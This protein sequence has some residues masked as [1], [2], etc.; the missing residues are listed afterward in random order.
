[1]ILLFCNNLLAPA[2]PDADFTDEYQAAVAAGFAPLLISL[3]ALADG[4]ATA[5]VRRVP[6][7]SQRQTAIY[8]GWMLRPADYK[9]LYAGLAAK[10]LHLLNSLVEYLTGH[11]FPKTYAQLRDYTPLSI[12]FDLP[13]LLDMDDLMARLAVFG[14]HP[15]IVKDYVKSEKHHWHEACFIP[16]SDNRT[17]VERVTRRFLELRGAYLN[18]GLVF[19]DFVD[20]E[21]L[22]NH[23]VSGMPLSKEFRLFYFRHRLLAQSTYWSEGDYAGV[24]P[25][26]AFFDPIAAR[27]SS[28][29]FTLD[30][31]KT[32]Q[33]QWLVLE[34]GDGQVSGLPETLNVGR[35]YAQLRSI[36]D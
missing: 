29:F 14:G 6:I 8:R 3:D 28:N 34:V 22:T 21:P 25:D 35:F 19:R 36:A 23:P 15:V 31:A 20:L 16:A 26:P 11:Y 7:F 32:R 1:M 18:E 5:A 12:S 24:R 10:N 9:A 33:G 17:T 30:V 4:D 27:I 2:Q 13:G